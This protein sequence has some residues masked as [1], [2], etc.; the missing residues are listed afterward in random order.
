M[1]HRRFSFALLVAALAACNGQVE[2]LSTTSP[3]TDGASGTAGAGGGS[4]G[5]AG[6]AGHAGTAGS[7]QAG[8]GGAG[9]AG[10]A[11]AAGTGGAQAGGS[12]QGG[13]A[14]GQAGSAGE[15]GASG[16]AGPGGMGGA[17]MAGA[18]AA[19]DGGAG[20]AGEGG[21]G[22]GGTGALTGSARPMRPLSTATVSSQ[23]P[24]LAWELKGD[25]VGAH[26][27]LCGDRA[28]TTILASFDAA[29]DHGAP[30]A[31]LPPGVVFWRLRARGPQGEALDTSPVWQFRVGYASA[32]HDTS[33]GATLDV[34][35]DGYDDL[36]LGAPADGKVYLYFGSP[37]GLAAQ[38]SQTLVPPQPGIGVVDSFGTKLATLGDINGDG[39]ADLAVQGCPQKPVN[40]QDYPCVVH[41]FLGSASGLASTPAAT[42]PG[43]DG[44]EYF[45]DSIAGATDTNNDGYSDV[46][47]TVWRADPGGQS[48]AYKESTYTFLGGPTIDSTLAGA[49][50]DSDLDTFGEV[51]GIGDLDGDGFGDLLV[52]SPSTLSTMNDQDYGVAFLCLGSPSGLLWPQCSTIPRLPGDTSFGRQVTGLGDINGDGFTDITVST[53]HAVVLFL[54]GASGIAKNPDVSLVLSPLAELV[55]AE[56]RVAS[57]GDLDHDGKNDVLVAINPNNG[58]NLSLQI[59]LSSAGGLAKAPSQTLEGRS[60]E[61]A[62]DD[63]IG[64][65]DVNGD[66]YPDMAISYNGLTKFHMQGSVEVYLG[67]AQ[68]FPSAPSVSI[69][70]LSPMTNLQDGVGPVAGMR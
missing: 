47:I 29:G 31:A 15:A 8:S 45:G 55:Y 17:G 66:G 40:G 24:T 10:K 33:W 57:V 64:L 34:N 70:K 62:V 65:G 44:Q 46:A 69:P 43:P 60:L 22:A 61:N 39:F 49:L 13:T 21:A 36:A 50:L 54:G 35:G 30:A 12:G 63:V 9:A 2:A 32:P 48:G 67:S 53:S 16:A 3:S 14:A 18:G 42:L 6:Q 20:A 26:V 4:A 5:S 1:R 51:E 27:D 52:S 28:C 11:G 23:T 19:G 56:P 68:G 7:V 41:L 38:P 58:A 59:Y 37:T 25:A